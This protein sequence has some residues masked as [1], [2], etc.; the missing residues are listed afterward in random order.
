MKSFIEAGKEAI[1]GEGPV[2]FQNGDTIRVSQKAKKFPGTFGVIQN[3][4]G[5]SHEVK[6]NNSD[7]DTASYK[8]SDLAFESTERDDSEDHLNETKES[9]VKGLVK[10]LKD[11]LIGMS[12]VAVV[13]DDHHNRMINDTQ[14]SVKKLL[15]KLK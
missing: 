8:S 7:R 6:L 4:D 11:I 9:L 14:E 1:L 10:N 12:E 13:M 5:D 2:Q 3:I 15:K